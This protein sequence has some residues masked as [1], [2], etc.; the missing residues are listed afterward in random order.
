VT[1]RLW[2]RNWIT[3]QRLELARREQ[4]VA[5]RDTDLR[6]AVKRAQEAY[7]RRRMLERLRERAHTAFLAGER[8]EE[9]K[10]LDELGALRFS[11]NRRG[12]PS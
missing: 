7:R 4:A 10:V 12:G 1:V 6:Q 5:D 2:Y 9:Q 3:A 8:R 11:L